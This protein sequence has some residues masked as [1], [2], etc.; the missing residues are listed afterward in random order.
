MILQ[1]GVQR[2]KFACEF[3]KTVIKRPKVL[4]PATAQ[5]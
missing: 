1:H 3:I 2:M 5:S 4:F